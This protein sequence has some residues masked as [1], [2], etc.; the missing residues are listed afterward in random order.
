M[1]KL[2]VEETRKQLNKLGMSIKDNTEEF[3][4]QAQAAL[5]QGYPLVEDMI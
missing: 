5:I 2:M 3:Y 4:Q 1:L